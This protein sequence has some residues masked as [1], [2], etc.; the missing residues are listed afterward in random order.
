MFVELSVLLFEIGEIQV[1]IMN[2]MY[3]QK[4]RNSDF[5]D[6]LGLFNDSFYWKK[7]IIQKFYVLLYLKMF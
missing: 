7:K 2:V 6:I 4:Q 3:L 1:R 5:C